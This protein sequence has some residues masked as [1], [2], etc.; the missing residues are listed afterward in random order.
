VKQT[1]VD[2]G[3]SLSISNAGATMQ[4]EN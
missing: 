3:A 4:S 2:N 1:N